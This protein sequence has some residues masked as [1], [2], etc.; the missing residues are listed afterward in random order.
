MFTPNTSSNPSNID[1]TYNNPNNQFKYPSY[2]QLNNVENKN[3]PETFKSP[4]TLINHLQTQKQPTLHDNLKNDIFNEYIKEYHITVDSLDRNIINY[5]DPFKFKLTLSNTFNKNKELNPFIEKTFNNV[6]YIKID[7]IICPIHNKINDK[8]NIND[9]IYDEQYANTFNNINKYLTLFTSNNNTYYD[10]KL[11]KYNKNYDATYTYNFLS[12]NKYDELILKTFYNN[13]NY[14]AEYDKKSIKYDEKEYND[15]IK[16]YESISLIIPNILINN[17]LYVRE[18]DNTNKYYDEKYY[19]YLKKQFKTEEE[20]NTFITERTNKNNTEYN[21]IYDRNNINFDKNAFDSL[22]TGAEFNIDE[23]YELNEND[24]LINSRFILLKMNNLTNNISLGTNQEVNNTN[25][26]FYPRK[27]YNKNFML[28][29]PII[30]DHNIFYVN[31]SNLINIDNIEFE[32]LDGNY[33]KIQFINKDINELD[34]N[35]IQSP[36]N[37]NFQVIFNLRIGIYQNYLDTNINYK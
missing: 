29:K 28:L 34:N 32:L 27:K 15:F 7:S 18:L 8:T 31:N 13:S 37:I 25:I 36:L 3:F 20:F 24:L 22:K 9:E 4:K 19:N 17:K 10:D 33:N 26:L 11:D 14:I 12:K 23:R 16:Y 6:K 30:K 2:I 5:P 1:F 35:K 21:E